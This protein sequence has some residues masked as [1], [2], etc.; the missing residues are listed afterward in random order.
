MNFKFD[1]AIDTSDRNEAIDLGENRT[2]NMTTGDHYL[3]KIKKIYI[4]FHVFLDI[5]LFHKIIILCSY[6]YISITVNIIIQNHFRISFLIQAILHYAAKI[7]RLALHG[8][9]TEMLP[10]DV[11][12][13]SGMLDAVMNMPDLMRNG[14][15]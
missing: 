11:K 2:S 7:V 12:R 3:K 15:K 1:V 8:S 4:D 13:N 5:L 14:R 6:D 9:D 10:A